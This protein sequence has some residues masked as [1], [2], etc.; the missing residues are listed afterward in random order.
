[1]VVVVFIVIVVV[2]GT[3]RL[4]RSKPAKGKGG[5]REKRGGLGE[6]GIVSSINRSY[7]ICASYVIFIII[8]HNKCWKTNV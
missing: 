4:G 1:M 8:I 7:L 2:L 5:G 3:V 6:I